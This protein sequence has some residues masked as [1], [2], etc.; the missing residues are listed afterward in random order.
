MPRCYSSQ[1]DAWAVLLLLAPAV[2][3]ALLVA[4]SVLERRIVDEGDNADPGRHDA[5]S[6]DRSFDA[7]TSSVEINAARNGPA[8]SARAERDA[9]TRA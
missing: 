9:A 2:E 4:S 8:M 5:Q 6:P 1:M 7:A 3:A